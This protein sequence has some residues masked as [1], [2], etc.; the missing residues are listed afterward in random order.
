MTPIKSKYE[1]WIIFSILLFQSAIILYPGW[2]VDDTAFFLFRLK[3]NLFGNV[4]GGFSLD[5]P[6]ERFIPFYYFGYQ[7]ISFLSFKPFF[8]FFQVTSHDQSIGNGHS[9]N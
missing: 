4:I 1:F 6:S 8:F 7:L 9:A 5:N 2:R 3:N